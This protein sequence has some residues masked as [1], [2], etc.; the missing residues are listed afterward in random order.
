MS[1]QA[2]SL[3]DMDR[4]VLAKAL[5]IQNWLI[6]EARFLEDPDDAVEG[7]VQR[8]IDAGVPLDRFTSAIPTLHAVRQGLGRK[9]A[10]GE[11]I[12]VL[13]FGWGNDEIYEAS[14]YALAH[15]TRDWVQFRLAEIDD[16]AFGVVAE[17][18]AGGYAHYIC[19]PVFFRDG[20]EGGLTFA[21]R[22]PEGFSAADLA[23]LRALE[24]SVAIVLDINRVWILL[25][26]TLRTY[27]G[28]EPQ[29]RILSGQV[30][31]GDVVPMRAAIVFADMRGFTTLSSALTVEETVVLLNRYF[32]SVVP[33]IE[34]AGGEVLKYIGD[35]VLAIYGAGDDERAACAKALAAAQAIVR[36]VAEDQAE[37]PAALR[38]D[39][40]VALHFGE[41][42]YGNIGSGA[43]LDYTV[44]GNGVN[45]ASRLADL[46]GILGHRLLV[47]SDFAGLL[48]DVGFASCGEHQLRGVGKP[49]TVFE[50]VQ[51]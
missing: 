39:I 44:V 7:F 8:L 10:R 6:G 2:S 31:R 51:V 29:A 34:E 46:A 30:R 45:L 43:R 49:Q 48:P 4:D 26:E 16:G 27:V 40:K 5:A 15:R 36:R 11:G 35:G 9:W 42:A 37:V 28:E 14:P 20:A 12:K 41:V 1:I 38:F 17:L 3:D 18:R 50:P 33:P 23:L 13:E 25:H 47:S 21:T 32:D 19:M 24:D 22:H